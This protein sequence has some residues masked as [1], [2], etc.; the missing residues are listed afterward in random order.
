MYL[1]ILAGAVRQMYIGWFRVLKNILQHT[2]RFFCLTH[3]YQLSFYG[4]KL[5]GDIEGLLALFEKKKKRTCAFMTSST[6]HV[7]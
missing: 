2:F 5:R 1:S 6:V 7:L 3:L 4:G